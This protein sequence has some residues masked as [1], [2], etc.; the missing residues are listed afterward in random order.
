MPLFL[1]LVAVPIIEI[2]LFIEVGGW[3]G[4]WPTLATVILTALIGTVLLRA[5]G[6]AA[7]SDLQRRVQSGQDPSPTIAHGAMI[8]VAGILLLTPGFFTDGIGFLL[9]T[10][11]VRVALIGYLKKRITLVHPGAHSSSQ[12]GFRYRSNPHSNP[13][14]NPG[15]VDGDYEVID[16]GLEPTDLQ[17][18]GP[19][20]GGTQ[21]SDPSRWT[22]PPQVD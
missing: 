2:A 6:L 5:Q 1:I 21:P 10:P 9:L 20:K 7:I 18:A 8:L 3:L 16:P 14:S 4:L 17:R 12:G 19:Q 22:K 13:H 15:T 11:P